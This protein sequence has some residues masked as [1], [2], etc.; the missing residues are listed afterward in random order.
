MSFHLQCRVKVFSV[1]K[2]H[3][4]VSIAFD[5]EMCAAIVAIV[6]TWYNVQSSAARSE[7]RVVR[8]L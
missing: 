3:S 8:D 2:L 6:A 7:V 4:G 1:E 5:C